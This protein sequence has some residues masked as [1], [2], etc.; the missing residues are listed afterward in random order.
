M[1]TKSSFHSKQAEFH[2][3]RYSSSGLDSDDQPFGMLNT[4]WIDSVTF[5]ANTPNWR[6]SLRDGID[7]TTTMNGSKSALR[8]TPG[9]LKFRK[10][11]LPPGTY[12]WLTGTQFLTLSLPSGDPSSV[13]TT[14]ATSFA[15][16]KFQQ[17]LNQV[18]TAIQGG[19]VIGE[20]GQ[21]LQMIRY[22]AQGL[23]RL[24]DVSRDV[25][26]RIRAQRRIAALA[27]HKRAVMKNLADAW[28]ELQF[29]WR[30]FLN[31]IKSGVDALDKYRQGQG[32]D[33][34]RITA[35]HTTKSDSA[36]STGVQGQSYAFVNTH[37]TTTERCDAIYRGA[38]R[39]EAV[40][41]QTLTA[42]LVGF[43]PRSF[44]PTAW[45]LLPYSFLIDYFTN[46][47]GII[48]GFSNLGIRLAWS[49]VTTRQIL[50]RRD[51]TSEYF[52]NPGVSVT[53]SYAE[54]VS[55]KTRVVRAKY[56]GYG[57]PPLAFTIPSF[58]SLKWLNIAALIAGRT[59]DR[60]WTFD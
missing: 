6:E 59:N 13:D 48:Y 7:A 53:G 11:I 42:K 40:D 15:L 9:L 49:N 60:K 54:V 22:P 31:D 27:S 34:H 5:G 16:G 12:I 26:W 36:D 1:T 14:N 55:S 51:W 29:G 18:G 38:V 39:V 10:D 2:I 52:Q 45:E 4:T 8:V 50:E 32:V 33:T 23:R 56:T 35:K 20:L 19:V 28:L 17:K 21:T 37:S 3:L 57:I 43:D 58:R 47:S 24:V 46:I 41:P 25:L 30:P 44:L